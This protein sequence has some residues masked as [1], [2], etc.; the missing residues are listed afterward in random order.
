MVTRGHGSIVNVSTM[1][2][3]IG[4]PG[5]TVYSST[6]A[7]L[8]SLTRTWA[9]EFGSSGVRVNTVAPGPTRTDNTIERMGEEFAAQI[10]A[11]TL[12]GRL[13]KTIE[14]AQVVL[15]LASDRSSYLTGATVAANAGRTAA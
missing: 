14:I 15:F 10:G 13:A 1:A 9:A 8:N 11:T 12:L 6:K 4:M 5:M 3:S 2:A 7:A